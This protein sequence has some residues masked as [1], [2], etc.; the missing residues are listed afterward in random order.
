MIITRNAYIYALTVFSFVSLI[1]HSQIVPSQ[2]TNEEIDR[3]LRGG[4]PRI[5]AWGASFAAKSVDKD[6]LPVLVGLAENYRSL[7]PQ[8]YDVRGNYIPRTPEQKQQLD[9]MQ[10]VLDSIIQLHGAVPFEVIIA[11][12]PDFPAQA[13]TLFATMSEPERSQRAIAL[14]ETR[15]KSDQSY[16]WHHQQMIHMAAAILALQPPPGFTAT[17]LDETTVTLKVSVTEDDQKRDGT[18]S[19][20]MCGDSFGLVPAPGW[21]QPYT[22]VVEQHWHSQRPPE[23]VLIPG[24]PAITTRRALSNSSCSALPGFTSVQRLLLARQEAGLPPGNLG[25]GTLQYDTLR[26]TDPAS[27]LASLSVLIDRHKA[28]FQKLAATLAGKSYITATESASVMPAFAVEIEDQ[29]NDR[30]QAL[31]IPA[32]LG[33]RTTIGPYKPESGS[34]LKQ[35]N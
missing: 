14:Y 17:L 30:S 4:D 5:V 12:L 13:L 33:P 35:S 32:S 29:R 7:P 3:W 34:F 8:E 15:D 19:G 10:S 9:S 31:P 16:D 26:Y 2:A 1:A 21:P 20:G 25:A 18:F 23:G 28:P 11:V 27:F 6:E 24:E 22:Y